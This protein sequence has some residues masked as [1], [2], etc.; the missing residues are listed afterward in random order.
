MNVQVMRSLASLSC[1]AAVLLVLPAC[2]VGS[3]P[4]NGSEE[5]DQLSVDLLVAQN[6]TI[7]GQLYAASEGE[8]DAWAVVSALPSDGTDGGTEPLVEVVFRQ[9]GVDDDSQML[10]AD[11]EEAVFGGP[12]TLDSWSRLVEVTNELE[13]EVEVSIVL[14]AI[15]TANASG[16]DLNL[17]LSWAPDE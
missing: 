10:A 1:L 8:L 9:T 6:E 11:G 5:S 12:L 3:A 13:R 15:A 14:F 4:S 2:T 17:E 7:G 16:E